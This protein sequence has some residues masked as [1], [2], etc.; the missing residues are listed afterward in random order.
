MKKT[1]YV[2]LCI[3]TVVSMVACNV[4]DNG[5]ITT[6]AS[7]T[8][9]TEKAELDNTATT[10]SN[11]EGNTDKIHE[12]ADMI[13]LSSKFITEVYG[14]T[15]G[16]LVNSIDGDQILP[17]NKE[18][19]VNEYIDES[20]TPSMKMEIL[21]T[22]YTLCY[23]MSYVDQ[24]SG[25]LTHCYLIDGTETSRV[26]FNAQTGDIIKCIGL[27]LAQEISTEEDSIEFIR[28]TL[29][30]LTDNTIDLAQYDYKSYTHVYTRSDKGMRSHTVE[31]YKTEAAEN[32]T[33]NYHSFMFSRSR[34]GITLP[35]YMHALIRDDNFRIDIYWPEYEEDD[36]NAFAEC[37][38]EVGEHVMSYI[39]LGLKDDYLFKNADITEYRLMV[40]DGIPYIITTA[41]VSIADKESPES[42]Y[43]STV[44]T[45]T[46][47]SEDI[48]NIR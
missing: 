4:A 30:Q 36:L 32:E 42:E 16:I 10:E 17:A 35:E 25:V 19:Y 18:I 40:K 27:P 8:T 28:S 34:G 14:N 48:P 22:E 24:Y 15:E 45:I 39:Q 46:A 1:L 23:E 9:P 13:Q 2:V 5:K 7:D 29:M 6:E 3:L 41:E 38:D 21:G 31:G 43:T 20:A 12:D 33:I 44:T 11:T 47:L 37:I 26:A